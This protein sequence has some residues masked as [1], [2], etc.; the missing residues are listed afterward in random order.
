MSRYKKG[1]VI[2]LLKYKVNFDR[3]GL[4]ILFLLETLLQQF[5]V[6]C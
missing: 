2:R 6:K 3:S 1:I 4:F 5:V